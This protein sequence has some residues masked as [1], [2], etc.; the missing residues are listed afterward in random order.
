MDPWRGD[1]HVGPYTAVVGCPFRRRE[2][3]PFHADKARCKASGM[4][5]QVIPCDPNLC[6]HQVE[7]QRVLEA[8][9]QFH[10]A[11][12]TLAGSQDTLQA[13]VAGLRQ[14]CEAADQQ[15]EEARRAAKCAAAAKDEAWAQLTTERSALTELR[16]T[17]EA[18][19]RDLAAGQATLAG[20]RA[21][22]QAER[23]TLA[24]AQAGVRAELERAQQE[25]DAAVK[26]LKGE[27]RDALE[28]W[29][30]LR[31]E[32]TALGAQRDALQAEIVHLR[33][34]LQDCE[35]RLEDARRTAG[36]LTAA[37]DALGRLA[38]EKQE[39]SEL[40][41]AAEALRREVVEERARL[42]KDQQD[43]AAAQ[44]AAR[45]EAERLAREIQ[46]RH[47]LEE[48]LHKSQQDA[49][50][51]AAALAAKGQAV[52][53][54]EAE[55][56]ALQEE[57]RAAKAAAG[58]VNRREEERESEAE[59]L[60]QERAELQ[61]LRRVV[62]RQ[63]S[64]LNHLQEQLERQQDHLAALQAV[65]GGASPEDWL[66]ETK[67]QLEA[68]WTSK[69]ADKQRELAAA[70][71]EQ[72]RGQERLVQ[73]SASLE[74][75]KE[76]LARGM[77]ELERE[78]QTLL[79]GHSALGSALVQDA[80]ESARRAWLAE[81]RE[82]AEAREA[83]MDALQRQLRKQA[84]SL[85]AL[86]AFRRQLVTDA[87]R[88]LDAG[89][90]AEE[91]LEDR[92]EYDSSAAIEDA[93]RIWAADEATRGQS[94]LHA[95]EALQAG[96]EALK[97]AQAAQ[98]TQLSE[99]QAE[100][101]AEKA[102]GERMR[103][104]LA[105]RG[106]A[107]LDAALAALD[108]LQ[109]GQ[110]QHQQDREH[111]AALQAT[112]AEQGQRLA[113]ALADLAAERGA[114]ERLRGEAAE[115]RALQQQWEQ[116]ARQAEE[117][118]TAA[119]AEA[120]QLRVQLSGLSATQMEE[121]QR[122]EAL[123]EEVA[124]AQ[125]SLGTVTQRLADA[126]ATLAAERAET[127]RVQTSAR[128][129]QQQL[130]E[131]LTAMQ[132]R[133]VGLEAA[134]AEREAQL[135]KLTEALAAEQAEVGLLR[136]ARA[137]GTR[138]AV[139]EARQEGLTAQQRQRELE[140]AVADLQGQL[141]ALPAELADAREEL[142]RLRQLHPEPSCETAVAKAREAWETSAAQEHQR[143]Q[144]EQRREQEELQAGH[145]EEVQRLKG[146]LEAE[147]A[148]QRL[149]G[150]AQAAALEEK[151]R[152][153]ASFQEQLET[154][155]ASQASHTRRISDVLEQ[156]EIERADLE[157]LRQSLP[158]DRA[159]L[160]EE[161]RAE[162]AAAEEERRQ[163]LERE[164]AALRVALEEVQ[165][166]QQRSS[167]SQAATS[168]APS[169]EVSAALAVEQ[170]R[171]EWEG[172]EAPRRAALEKQVAGLRAELAAAEQDREAAVRHL[173]AEL[174]AAHIAMA[175][176]TDREAAAAKLHAA[177]P[178]ASGSPQDS[179]PSADPATMAVADPA[180]MRRLG[181]LAAGWAD[182]KRDAILQLQHETLALDDSVRL[183]RNSKLRLLRPD[184]PTPS[185]RRA[186]LIKEAYWARVREQ[187]RQAADVEHLPFAYNDGPYPAP[188][189]E[190]TCH[191]WDRPEWWLYA[192]V[193][194][195]FDLLLRAHQEFARLDQGH[196]GRVDLRLV[197]EW[198]LAQGFS[199]FTY[200]QLMQML[201][202]VD[203]SPDRTQGFWGFLGVAVYLTLEL[204]RRSIPLQDWLAFCLQSPAAGQGAAV[205]ALGPAGHGQRRDSHV[206][207][208]G[209]SKPWHRVG[210]SA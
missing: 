125:A 204:Y 109:Q 53:R 139:Q 17:V 88:R 202:Q 82:R 50:D 27:L 148:E 200:G 191:S 149:R 36:E 210:G 140:S 201:R 107:D 143:E 44:A 198:C 10:N 195:N 127:G 118:V 26:G 51:L 66:A 161:A 172:A 87:G 24:A 135:A 76:Q 85:A 151:Q 37:E 63:K 59:A 119:K 206:T 64:D 100:L 39:L 115:H 70:A 181:D 130:Q 203:S 187:Q 35:R 9:D 13:E 104:A 34:G 92:E 93:K 136:I 209:P 49:L 183:L 207:R 106:L 21:A 95:L 23:G 193:L 122:M 46:T 19:R 22:L 8:W 142:R 178:A 45:N 74:W 155:R 153:I 83:E 162:W 159:T 190:V 126:Q 170:A 12:A 69:A 2:D 11:N 77:V 72:Q 3:C 205:G 97:A 47:T 173:R 58:E 41:D 133:V 150:A 156:V 146:Q 20:E 80:L 65:L 192:D 177:N 105:H 40:R 33:A 71:V 174:E 179:S 137:E 108:A 14:R 123:Q 166:Q 152:E 89:A 75:E 99:A 6:R 61:R 131:E 101:L 56:H 169:A 103:E 42:L 138:A 175:E 132:G 124:A 16:A 48:Q 5:E 189:P 52:A 196:T 54:A 98:A 188:P 117:A 186:Q 208:R 116:Q 145:Q 185:K 7:L 31:L 94:Q 60:A 30:A 96:V 199:H 73:L 4:V 79:A 128:Q 62:E 180:N 114:A 81:E 111:A 1:V 28:A 197:G 194:I 171:R 167:S 68:E 91:L 184:Q 57:L 120:G 84:K 157:K 154:L 90:M 134:V 102:R 18:L 144:Q 129:A 168:E 110:Q 147:R 15:L 121:L 176:A 112:V 67:K 38:R 164:I 55:A 32:T 141:A 182:A 113:A 160:L 163:G 78:R 25:H 29:D 43:A 165:A 86:R 158:Q